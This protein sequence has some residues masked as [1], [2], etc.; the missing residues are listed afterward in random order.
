M[1]LGLARDAEHCAFFPRKPG[2]E[3]DHCII[4]VE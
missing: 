1:D 3:S 4:D 2:S